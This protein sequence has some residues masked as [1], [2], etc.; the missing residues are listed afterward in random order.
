MLY[1]SAV[2][3]QNTENMRERSL[4]GFQMLVV[5]K[6]VGENQKRMNKLNSEDLEI[7]N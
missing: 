1:A 2:K 4:L 6:T 5:Y 3:P 7:F